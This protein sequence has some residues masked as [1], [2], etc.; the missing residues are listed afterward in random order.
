MPQEYKLYQISDEKAVEIS[1]PNIHG[2]RVIIL[3]GLYDLCKSPINAGSWNAFNRVLSHQLPKDANLYTIGTSDTQSWH[4][5]EWI[6]TGG[7]ICP[8]AKELAEQIFLLPNVAPIPDK[9]AYLRQLDQLA[10][11]TVFVTLS[12]GSLLL[13]HVRRYLV[14]RLHNDFTEAELSPILAK[15]GAVNIAPIHTIGIAPE[16]LDFTQISFINKADINAAEAPKG[17]ALWDEV[18][19]IAQEMEKHWDGQGKNHNL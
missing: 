9:E 11:N 3:G 12:T 13:E 14:E 19:G 6:K 2:R 16:N 8:A 1:Q 7:N 4:E 15:V 10:A 18:K 17:A 5:D